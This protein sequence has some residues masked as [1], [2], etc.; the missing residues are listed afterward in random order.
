MIDL[1]YIKRVNP[2]VFDEVVQ[3]N[4][5][6]IQPGQFKD[7][8][9]V[10]VGAHIGTFSYMAHAVGQAQGVVCLEPNAKNF[11]HLVNFLGHEFG[12][13]LWKAAISH[14]NQPVSITDGDNISAVGSGGE[15]VKAMT[16]HD[17]VQMWPQWSGKATLKM[18]VE[19]SEYAA[20]WSSCI[21]TVRFFHT[22]LL[23][24][25]GTE[26]QNTAMNLYLE[27]LGYRLIK[28]QRMFRWDVLPDGSTTNWQPLPA[29]VSCF[30]IC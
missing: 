3:R 2:G 11:D 25:H 4:G 21:K 9:V 14:D 30:K 13:A 12:F 1:E 28:Q 26:Q 27:V 29:W 22:I 10:D 6:D 15:S 8:L 18:D 19:G 24:T 5:Y 20:L 23:E 7:Q 17:I 16:L